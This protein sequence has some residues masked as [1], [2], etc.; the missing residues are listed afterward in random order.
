MMEGD[1]SFA[2]S[3]EVLSDGTFQID[4]GMLVYGVPRYY[5]KLF[6]AKLKP[7][8]V[9]AGDERILVDTGIG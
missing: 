3:L 6:R 1:G 9:E 2:D 8:Y 5:G 4:G 7:M